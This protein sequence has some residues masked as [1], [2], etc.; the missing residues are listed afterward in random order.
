VTGPE[1]DTFTNGGRRKCPYEH[2]WNKHRHSWA[3]I[4]SLQATLSSLYRCCLAAPT[5]SFRGMPPFPFPAPATQHTMQRHV[6]ASYR[7][8]PA[9][10]I[11][12][13]TEYVALQCIS[14]RIVDVSYRRTSTIH[15]NSA[16]PFAGMY[17]RGDEGR[18][19][20]RSR[21]PSLA[22]CDPLAQAVLPPLRLAS[23]LCC[24]PG[25]WRRE[26]ED[27]D[28]RK[29]PKDSDCTLHPVAV[30]L[31]C[32]K[33]DMGEEDWAKGEERSTKGQGRRLATA[34]FVS[35]RTFLWLKLAD[36]RARGG[37]QVRGAA[38]GCME[39]CDSPHHS[40]AMYPLAPTIR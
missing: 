4:A 22:R 37:G 38:A 40:S 34:I 21:D 28:V 1:T 13:Q 16:L 39:R 15:S 10:I 5:Q 14:S 17:L 2:R 32:E 27:W 23:R 26:G 12:P 36:E 19:A 20:P 8:H 24:G 11:S 18:A 31:A 30:R 35:Q 7:L 25:S 6:L 3:W 29:R 33:A 9:L